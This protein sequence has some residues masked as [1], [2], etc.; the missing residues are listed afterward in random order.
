[1]GRLSHRE[2]SSAEIDG[3]VSTIRIDPS[4]PPPTASV[5]VREDVRI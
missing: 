5:V 2:L 1:M 4:G 3:A